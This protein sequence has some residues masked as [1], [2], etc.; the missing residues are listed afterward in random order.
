[1]LH[2]LLGDDETLTPLKRVLTERAQGNPFFLEESVWALAEASALAGERGRYHLTGRLDALDVPATIQAVLAARIDRLSPS[3]KS[4]LQAASVIG[5]DIPLPLLQATSELSDAELPV[6]LASLQAAE[7]LYE[8]KFVPDREYRFNHALTQ[9]VAYQTLL[10]ERRRVLHGRVVEGI[11]RLYDERLPE[12]VD[13]LAQ[14]AVGSAVWEKACGYLQQAGA[15]A[16]ARSAYQEAASYFE[17]AQ[18]GR[19]HV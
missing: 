3:A 12:W 10:H 16:K 6:A 2:E 18:I 11:E 19:A 8:A 5:T 17:Q 4:L 14:H 1:M 7:F 9:D 13:R 15:K